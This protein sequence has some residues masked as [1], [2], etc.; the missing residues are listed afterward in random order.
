MKGW[1]GDVLEGGLLQQGVEKETV[2]KA[3]KEFFD[4]KLPGFVVENIDT[5]PEYYNTLAIK[6]QRV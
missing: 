4:E 5:Y 6:L 3:S 1:W 2:K